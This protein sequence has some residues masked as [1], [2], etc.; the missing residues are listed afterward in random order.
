MMMRVVGA[1]T[2]FVVLLSGPARVRA[3]EGPSPIVVVRTL[4]LNGQWCRQPWDHNNNVVV[5]FKNVAAQTIKDVVFAVLDKD[6]NAIDRVDDAGT[7]SSN[8]S[9][10]HVFDNPYD[11]IG[12]VQVTFAAVEA[13]FADGST[14]KTTGYIPPPRP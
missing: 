10:T 14:W 13:T 8:V 2:A 3:G 1:V 12:P 7:F 5:T 9:I 11:L 6:G 4:T